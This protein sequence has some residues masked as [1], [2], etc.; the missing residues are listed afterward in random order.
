LSIAAGIVPGNSTLDLRWLLGNDSGPPVLLGPPVSEPP[1]QIG[2]IFRKELAVLAVLLFLG[3]AALPI[4]IWFVGKAV[5]G[6]YGGAGYMDFY[7][8]LSSKIRSGDLVSW[9]LVLSPYLVWQIVRLT[10]LGWR[11]AKKV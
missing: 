3:L 10:A 1:S 5:F 11:A 6:A 2:R 7:G 4:V 9:F 8:T